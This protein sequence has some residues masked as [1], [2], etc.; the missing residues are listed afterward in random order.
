MPALLVDVF[1]PEYINIALSVILSSM[2]LPLFIGYPFFGKN[3]YKCF[4]IRY[5]QDVSSLH[6]LFAKILLF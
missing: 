3:I 5:I 4:S 2:A 1:G 6:Y